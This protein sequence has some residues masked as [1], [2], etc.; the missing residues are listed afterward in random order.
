MEKFLTASPPNK[1]NEIIT[2]NVVNDV[3]RVLDKVW[4]IDL[5]NTSNID[6]FLNTILFSLILSNTTMESFKEY[7]ITA[8]IAARTL[9][10]NVKLK[11][12]KNP[13]VIMTSCINAVI[14]PK[15]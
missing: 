8:S 6:N 9:R 2:S 1:S 12:E 4:L 7:P 13:R 10:S 3:T 11:R 14:A 15:T 5:F